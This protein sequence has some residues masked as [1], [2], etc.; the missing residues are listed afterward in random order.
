MF[1]MCSKLYTNNLRQRRRSIRATTFSI[2]TSSSKLYSQLIT[3]SRIYIHAYIGVIYIP[4]YM[5]NCCIY[6]FTLFVSLVCDEHYNTHLLLVIS[7]QENSTRVRLFIYCLCGD[8]Y[9]DIIYI[10][11]L[12]SSRALQSHLATHTKSHSIIF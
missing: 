10:Q 2:F 11:V 12:F 5:F 6:L 1:K 8:W 9:L 7:L 3:V 4:I